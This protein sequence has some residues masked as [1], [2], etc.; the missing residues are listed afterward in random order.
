MV[1]QLLWS[2]HNVISWPWQGSCLVGQMALV[3]DSWGCGCYQSSWMGN[4]RGRFLHGSGCLGEWPR[5]WPK[6]CSLSVIR[7]G[8]LVPMGF[9]GQACSAT[10]QV[11]SKDWWS[12]PSSSMDTLSRPLHTVPMSLLQGAGMIHTGGLHL[13]DCSCTH[14]L[15]F[16]NCGCATGLYLH[17][18]FS[19]FSLIHM[20][21]SLGIWN[22]FPGMGIHGCPGCE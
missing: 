11:A 3:F 13:P 12:L 9:W 6:T 10:L 14:S 22:L 2:S 5:E 18:G 20:E 15:S 17:Y 8:T 21:S 16:P 1:G 7:G 19:G 4:H